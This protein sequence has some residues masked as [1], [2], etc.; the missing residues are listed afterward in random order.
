MSSEEQRVKVEEDNV[1]PGEVFNDFAFI[2]SKM[3]SHWVVMSRRM[4][5]DL[6]L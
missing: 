5:Y 3:R 1:G 4:I 2:W 6:K